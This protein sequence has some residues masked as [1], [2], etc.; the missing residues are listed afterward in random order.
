MDFGGVLYPMRLPLAL[1][2]YGLLKYT[3]CEARMSSFAYPIQLQR[4]S[5]DRDAQ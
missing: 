4:V 1:R 2:K 3:F 5:D